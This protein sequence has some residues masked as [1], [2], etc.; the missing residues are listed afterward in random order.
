METFTITLTTAEYLALG[1]VAESQQVWI[2]NAVRERCRIAT[3][4][5]VAITVQQCLAN[6]IQIPGTKDDIVALA[7]QQGWIKSAAQV[8]EDFLNSMPT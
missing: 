8:N 2:E 4:E 3:D 5:I 6:N 7:F 1:Y